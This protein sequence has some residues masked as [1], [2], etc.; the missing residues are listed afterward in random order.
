MV[1]FIRNDAK[2]YPFLKIDKKA[3]GVPRL[4]LLDEEDNQIEMVYLTD[5]S[6]LQIIA[7]LEDLKI[8][9]EAPKVDVEM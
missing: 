7:L 5:K 8:E 1:A 6:R 9:E 2:N 4:V 3:G